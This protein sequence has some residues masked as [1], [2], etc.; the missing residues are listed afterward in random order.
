MNTARKAFSE[1]TGRLLR[2]LSIL[3]PSRKR[4]VNY[5]I[6]MGLTT[7]VLVWLLLNF[8]M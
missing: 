5:E 1:S 3:V 8:L 6:L 7:L 4:A 2:K